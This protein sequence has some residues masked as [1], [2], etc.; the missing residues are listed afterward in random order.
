MPSESHRDLVFYPP[1]NSATLP[2]SSL[3]LKQQNAFFQA[4]KEL[5]PSLFTNMS[6]PHHRGVTPATPSHRRPDGQS[7]TA[8]EVLTMSSPSILPT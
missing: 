6:L 2:E 8:R 7:P 3:A 4:G 1:A 5:Q